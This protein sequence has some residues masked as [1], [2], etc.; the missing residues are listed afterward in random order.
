[1]NFYNLGVRLFGGPQNNIGVLQLLRGDEWLD[2]S[3]EN[4]DGLAAEVACRYVVKHK[5]TF[6]IYNYYSEKYVMSHTKN[7]IIWSAY[8]KENV[9]V[10]KHRISSGFL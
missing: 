8:S 5:N 10:L 2:V 1:M 4:F 3:D 7:D 6:N 9:Y